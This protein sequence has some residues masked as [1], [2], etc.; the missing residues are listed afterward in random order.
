MFSISLRIFCEGKKENN[1]FTFIIKMQ[2][3]FARAAIA[4]IPNARSVF[5]GYNL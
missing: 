4:P 3:I 5:V 2:I 1:L